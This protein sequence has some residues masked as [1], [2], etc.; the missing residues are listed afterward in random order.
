MLHKAQNRGFVAMMGIGCV[1]SVIIAFASLIIFGISKN[2][3]KQTNNGSGGSSWGGS[4]ETVQE[5]GNVKLPYSEGKMGHEQHASKQDCFVAGNLH[6]DGP[7][8]FFTSVGSVNNCMSFGGNFTTDQE[9]WYF[10]MRWEYDGHKSEYQHTKVVIY[11]PENQVTVVTS[12]EEYGPHHCLYEGTCESYGFDGNVTKG[13]NS[14]APPEVYNCL[15]TPSPYTA[16]PEQGKLQYGIAKDQN[17]PLGPL[18]GVC[19]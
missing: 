11:N 13:M 4:V 14:G 15:N 19:K 1:F 6:Y 10:N 7:L 5:L 12:I 17:I 18:N 2:M 9:R 8:S 16:D 3:F